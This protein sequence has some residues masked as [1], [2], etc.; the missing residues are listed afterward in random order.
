MAV[1]WVEMM[2]VLMGKEKVLS[3]VG[4]R[5]DLWVELTGRSKVDSMATTS[6]DWTV[7]REVGRWADEREWPWDYSA[8]DQRVDQ[9]V[10]K[11]AGKTDDVTVGQ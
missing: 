9:W 10:V 3:L 2:A 7:C 8:V 5:V 1:C 4:W 11:K 6:V